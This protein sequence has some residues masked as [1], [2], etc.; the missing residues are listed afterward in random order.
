MLLYFFTK[1]LRARGGWSKVRIWIKPWWLPH[2][3]LFLTSPSHSRALAI[4][5]YCPGSEGLHSDR[6]VPRRGVHAIRE[7]TLS[8]T[9]TFPMLQSLP[10]KQYSL[11]VKP[12]LIF[13]FPPHH[14]CSFQ[15]I[16]FLWF[17]TKGISSNSQQFVHILQVGK[18]CHG[19]IKPPTQ[20]DLLPFLSCSV[21]EL[22]SRH[23]PLSLPDKSLT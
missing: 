16:A 13:S 12:P 1:M 9:Q 17:S 8:G 18:I 2:M 19:D 11:E 21:R 3:K 22:P 4:S 6:S 15:H 23:S 20:T 14:W 5:T 7:R 10:Y